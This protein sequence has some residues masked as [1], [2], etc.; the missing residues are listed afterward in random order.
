MRLFICEKPS[1][2]KDIAPHVGAKTRGDGCITGDGVVVTWAIGHL[3]EQAKPEHYKPA[4]RS[5]N[6]DLLPVIPDRWA[7]E[8]KEKTRSQYAA[9]S[10]LLKQ[11]TEVVIA[12]DADR[13]GEVIARE[14]LE[15][16]GY[17][18]PVS[19]LWLSAFDDASIRKAVAK[20]LPGSKTLPMYYSGMGRGRGDW[21]AGMNLTMALTCAFG[22]GGKGGTLHCGRVQTPVLALIVRRERAIAN[23]V[24]K[25][26]Y[27]LAAA[28]RLA[29]VEVPMAWQ[30]DAAL[31]DKD[32]H[33]LDRARA[34]EAAKRVAGR[35]G[36]VNLVETTA[37]REP[38]PLPYSLGALQREASARFGLKAQVVLDCAQALYEK[39]KAT[40][41]PRTDCEH[42]PVS[43]IAEASAALEAVA[44]TTPELKSH[45]QTALQAVA[46][47][48]F[49]VRAFNDRKITAHHAIIPTQNRQVNRQAMNEA[50]RIVYDLICRRYV[51]QFLPDH[52]FQKTV[53]DVVCEGERFRVTGKTL[54]VTG[55]RALYPQQEPKHKPAPGEEGAEEVAALPGVRMG[56]AATN[57]R[58][59]VVARKTAPPKR[60][61][62]GTLLAAMEAIDREIED[63]RWKAIMKNKEKAGIGT[64]ATRSAIIEGLFK[65]EYIEARKKELHPT[66]KGHDLIALIEQVAPEI[67]DPVLTAQW[68]DRLAQIEKGEQTLGQ[69]EID[70]AD[71][72]AALLD[73]I[74]QAPPRPQA[75]PGRPT[76]PAGSAA[77]CPSCGKPMRRING[78]KGYF[79]GCTGYREGCKTTLPDANGKPGEAP[80]AQASPYRCPQCHKP[81]KRIPGH[82]G[83]FWGCTAYPQCRHT[84]PDVDGKPGAR[85]EVVAGRSRHGDAA[86]ARPPQRGGRAGETCPECGKGLL[87][88]KTMKDSGKAFVGCNRFPACRFF[89]WP[90][91]VSKAP[92]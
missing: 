79:W 39:H 16:N 7:M 41:Y 90:Q 77:Y 11:A 76:T 51:A 60:Y 57:V 20:L 23:F 66:A 61:T 82:N 56:D 1:Q 21:L 15:L 78:Q 87:V 52:E 4:L 81:L 35:T 50:E 89:A 6:L 46:R 84:Q 83:Y 73:K 38:A 8:I 33:V 63:P 58:C 80:T 13:E 26:H 68:E 19:R 59:E 12:T 85:P 40:T 24:P 18:G 86:G 2:A 72:L 70:L 44:L 27:Q 65:R 54:T 34:A 71:W 42:M 3:L 69:F 74:R 75:G 49:S 48:G 28:F 92:G 9:I 47:P 25:T 32:G 55:W 30:P 31:V 43:M 36:S 91:T 88:N 67:A 62:E 53:I 64:D 29:G 14:L 17:R 5:W 45:A 22:A 10:K 37:Q